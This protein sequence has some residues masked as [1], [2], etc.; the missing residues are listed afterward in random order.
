MNPFSVTPGELFL[1]E[2]SFD[3]SINT[4]SDP[5]VKFAFKNQ[6]AL[7][8]GSD[9]KI[10]VPID[11]IKEYSIQGLTCSEVKVKDCEVQIA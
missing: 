7:V 6:H 3:P 8:S 5:L 2:M 11:E 10:W 4:Q 1:A 9:I